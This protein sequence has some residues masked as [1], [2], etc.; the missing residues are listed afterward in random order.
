MI[1]RICIIGGVA[2]GAGAAAA[3][4]RANESA[5]IDLYE[6][7]PYISFANCGL[8]YYLSG[9]IESRDRLLIT[10]PVMMKRRFN[11]DVHVRHLVT[12]IDRAGKRIHVKN[13]ES[14]AEFDQP[15]DRLV[16]ATGARSIRPPAA[17]LE[18]SRIVECRTVEDVD[19]LTDLA[20][21]HP[22]GRALVI[23]CGFIGLEV[24]EALT[25][26][27]LGV[28]AL[29]LATQI[30]PPLDAEIAGAGQEELARHGVSVMLGVKVDRFEHGEKDSA[31]LLSNG[32][33]I[34][35]DFAVL[36]IG[37]APDTQLAKEAG[38][39]LGASGGVVVDDRQQ[40]SDPDIFAAGDVTELLYW[41]TNTR[42]KLALAGPANKQARV[43]GA[44]AASQ[45]ARLLTTGAAGT[46]IVRLFNMAFGMTGLSEKAAQAR[47]VPYRVVYTVNGHHAGYFPGARPLSIKLL[48]SPEG[49]VLG[50]QVFG[51]EG[52][53]KRLDVLATA[54]QGKFTV[55]QLAELDLA[56]A[57]PFGA[58]KDPLIVAGMVASN[59][60]HGRTEVI[61][62]RELAAEMASAEKPLI[63][64][65]RSPAEHAAGK[66][67]GS[68]NIPVDLLRENLKQLPADRA[69]VIHCAVGYRGYVAERILRQRGFAKVRNL[70]G[71]YRSWQLH[72]AT[73]RA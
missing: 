22:Q 6:A 9:E 48:F 21:A 33:R 41:P 56:Y 44:N 67:D 57:P 65:V 29:D 54:I 59:V 72:A 43:A 10:T 40:T 45:E 24:A 55:D 23:G 14:G 50:G 53:D 68:L 31:A 30:L 19:R 35:F 26:R 17:G 39:A 20:K 61:T 4:R 47:Q 32:Q 73:A 49:R 13:L 46:S 25:K 58:A 62:P 34:T 8:P 66:I 38:L 7:G 11:I 2:G 1:Q 27:G 28:T 60:V 3:A 42:M 18:H 15:Y 16:L 69:I 52:V 51:A 5:S 12:G 70:T 36:S 71:G 63:L 64:D 37:V